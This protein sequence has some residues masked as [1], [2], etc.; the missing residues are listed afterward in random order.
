MNEIQDSIDDLLAGTAV[1]GIAL[2]GDQ[3]ARFRAY[4]TLLVEW[5]ERF[6]LL[7]PAAVRELWSRHLLDALTIVLA[8]PHGAA[9]DGMPR[10]LID[11][12][13]GAGLPGIPLRILFPHW[14]VTLL[15]ATSKKVRFLELVARELE[16]DN[17][18]AVTGRAEEV[19]HDREHREAYDICVARAVTHTAALV[20]LTL[21]FVT[22][23]G[24]AI[25]YKGLN[26]LSEEVQAAEPAR[27]ILGAA[28]PAVIPVTAPLDSARCLVRYVKQSRTP[29]QLP[30]RAGV[31]EQRPLT[32][33]DAARIRAEVAAEARA[34]RERPRRR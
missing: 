10:T 7:G 2:D 3:L 24:S 6:N 21:P 23:H 31:P 13:S 15:D 14:A 22:M 34:R 11:V 28:A 1:L 4:A 29:R 20:E 27:V 8:L 32:Q 9:T 5:N 26:G 33:A 16:L 19:A 25:L 12:G 17:V 30:R 18:Q